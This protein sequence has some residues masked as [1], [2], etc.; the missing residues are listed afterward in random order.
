MN[1][2]ED[3]QIGGGGGGGRELDFAGG[4]FYNSVKNQFLTKQVF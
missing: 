2:G 3:S 1:E 4:C